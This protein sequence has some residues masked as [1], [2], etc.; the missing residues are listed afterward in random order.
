[1]YTWGK[2]ANGRLGHGDIEDINSPTLVEALKDKQVKSVVCGS[3]FTASICLH[4]WVSGVDQSMC[5]GCGLPFGFTIKHHNCY[6]C[7]LVFCH[8]CSAKKSLKASLAPNPNKPYR[9]RDNC[10]IKLK[11]AIEAGLASN[12]LGIKRGTANQRSY[13]LGEKQERFEPKHSYSFL[14]SLIWN[15]VNKLRVDLSLEE[16][17]SWNFIEAEYLQFQME[18]HSGGAQIFHDP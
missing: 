13:D 5:S 8:A 1:M 9:V 15:H 14:G 17:G 16:I 2:G 12:T 4:K 11:K 10:Y 18:I 7:G 3:S 6:N